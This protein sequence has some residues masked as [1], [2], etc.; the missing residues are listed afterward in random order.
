MR[1]NRLQL[2]CFRS[3]APIAS[4]NCGPCQFQVSLRRNQ[5]LFARGYIH[6]RRH[7]IRLDS[8]TGLHVIVHRTQ[9]RRRRL[10][11]VLGDFNLPLRI[12]HLLVR[13]LQRGDTIC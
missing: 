1:L 9:Q 5:L 4:R 3:G 11:L 7:P 13:L 8:K 12:E 10:L 6:L 2:G